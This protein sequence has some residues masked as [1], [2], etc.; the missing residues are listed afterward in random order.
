MAAHWKDIAHR[1]YLSDTFRRMSEALGSFPDD[2]LIEPYLAISLR[3]LESDR[4]LCHR[5]ARFV[6]ACVAARYL[7]DDRD[8]VIGAVDFIANELLENAV[9]FGSGDDIAI[10]VGATPTDLA[11]LVENS[12]AAIRAESLRDVLTALTCGK[13]GELLRQRAERNAE[14]GGGSGLGLLSLMHDYGA[15][16]G[17]D[18]A[19]DTPDTL[20]LQIIVRLPI[21]IHA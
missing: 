19:A 21:N 4:I 3:C 16:L 8:S 12:V 11:C 13:P 18:L 2:D 14:E 6:A 10:A 5:T 9:K 20:R 7:G 15:R 1:M 17:W